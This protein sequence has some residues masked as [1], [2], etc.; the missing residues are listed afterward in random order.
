M[1]SFPFEMILLVNETIVLYFFIIFFFCTFS[2]MD[3]IAQQVS[4]PL[5]AT[6]LTVTKSILNEV[7]SIAEQ[8]S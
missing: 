3:D 8:T 1:F 7:I 2:I 6:E 5:T 4:D